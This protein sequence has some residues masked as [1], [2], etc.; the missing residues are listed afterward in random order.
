M[1][2]C[3]ELMPELVALELEAADQKHPPF[4]STHEGYAVLKEEIE[5][6]KDALDE[7]TVCLQMMWEHIKRDHLKAYEYADKVEKYAVR[8]AAE[9]IQVAAMAQKFKTSGGPKV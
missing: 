9:A 8:L 5:E 3:E 1:N 7:V 2:R 4:H 6:A